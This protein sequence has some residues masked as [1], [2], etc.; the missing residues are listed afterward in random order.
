MIKCECLRVC[1]RVYICMFY[2][3]FAGRCAFVCSCIYFTKQSPVG[4]CVYTRIFHAA[5]SS[6]CVMCMYVY[7]YVRVFY[8]RVL[9]TNR[10]EIPTS[11][12]TRDEP[13][14]QCCRGKENMVIIG[15]GLL[16]VYYYN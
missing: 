4:L 15:L 3:I 7:T 9:Q 2:K 12:G 13:H 10:A 16:L 5:I 8:K 14:C 6:S 11:H 1:V